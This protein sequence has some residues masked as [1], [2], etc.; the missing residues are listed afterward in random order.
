MQIAPM[1]NTPTNTKPIIYSTLFVCFFMLILLVL[2]KGWDKSPSPFR[3]NYIL[4]YTVVLESFQELDQLEG[5]L[6]A[7]QLIVRLEQPT[8][9]PEPMYS[10][11][12]GMNIEVIV[13][14]LRKAFSLIPL[15]VFP[16]IV[17][18][19]VTL[20]LEPLYP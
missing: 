19:I 20:A 15:T 9:A 17:V 10:I 13:V 8:N 2:N 3:L 6:A 11:Q 14:L 1:H 18:G 16:L 5:A 7:S 12:V 4:Q